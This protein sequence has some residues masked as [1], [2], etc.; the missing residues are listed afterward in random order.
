MK[1]GYLFG[2]KKN[3]MPKLQIKIEANRLKEVIVDAIEAQET[4]DEVANYIVEVL[5]K[6][7]IE[8]K[9]IVGYVKTKKESPDKIY[10]KNRKEYLLEVESCEAKYL[11]CEKKAVE[12]H[13][14]FQYRIGRALYDQNQFVATCRFCHR[15]IHADPKKAIRRGLLGSHQE[16][17]LYRKKISRWT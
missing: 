15:E 14:K 6:F 9:K 2:I 17:A 16:K 11:G 5:L 10:E 13:H 1:M 4:A 8:K 7:Q 12:I 3:K